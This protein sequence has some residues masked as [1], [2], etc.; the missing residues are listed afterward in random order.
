MHFKTINPANEKVIKEYKEDSSSNITNLVNKTHKAYLDW[1]EQDFNSRS[2]ILKNV[3][4]L[5]LRKKNEAAE[6]MAV[7]MGKPISQGLV[8]IE[9]SAWVCE[10]YALNT[11]E[12]L[13][14]K[15]IETEHSKSYVT[16]KPIG[17]LYAIMPWNFP[18]WQVFRVAAPNL[19]AGNTILLKHAPN[20]P[21]CSEFI[22]KIFLE[23]GAPKGILEDILIST[24][25]VKSASDFIIKNPYIAG[26]T[27]TGSGRAGASVASLSGSLLKKSVLELGGSDPYIIMKDADLENAAN[28]CAVSRMNN[29]GQTCIAAKRFIV[30]KKI[31]DDFLSLLIEKCREFVPGEPLDSETNMGPLARKDLQQT[32]HS[33]VHQS[34]NE[35]GKLIIGGELPEIKGYYYPPTIIANIKPDSNSFNEEIFGPV[36]SVITY[37]TEEEAI[38]LANATGFGLGAAI[39]TADKSKGESIASQ[40]LEAGSCFVNQFVKSDPRLPFGGIKNS[41]YGRELSEYGITEFLN[42]K[43]VVVD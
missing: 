37:K 27:L 28:H 35:G 33:Q 41:G 20:V 36:A 6:L 10:H 29:T 9:K 38:K 15:Y 30:D 14:D 34:I 17:V 23:A 3:S 13:K 40:K 11:K 7:E 5:L 24:D 43:T 1:R 42:I 16:F 39:F 18:F 32:I 22:K 4:E 26:V 19:M 12:L 8:E 25:S 21:Q 31:E 2:K